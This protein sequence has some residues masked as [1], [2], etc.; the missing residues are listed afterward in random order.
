MDPCASA[1]E[2]SSE[3]GSGT[4]DH[5]SPSSSLSSAYDVVIY[6]LSLD[7]VSLYLKKRV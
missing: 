1:L 4:L 2:L 5:L 7:I 3:E 6:M